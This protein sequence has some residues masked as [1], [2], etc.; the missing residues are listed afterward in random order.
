MFFHVLAHNVKNQ[1]I[2]GEFVRSGETI[3]WH[4]NI[5]LLA[6]LCL[7]DK[8]LKKLQPVT[9]ACIDPQWKWFEVLCFLHNRYL[10]VSLL[11]YTYSPFCHTTKLS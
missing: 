7:H 11:H 4:F 9:N 6:V 10:D 5:V 1:V 8:L 2:Q 3:L